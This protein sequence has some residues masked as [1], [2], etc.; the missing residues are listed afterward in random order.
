MKKIN[1]LHGSRRGNSITLVNKTERPINSIELLLKGQ[2]RK[3]EL[4]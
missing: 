4:N 2:G 3:A 1:N